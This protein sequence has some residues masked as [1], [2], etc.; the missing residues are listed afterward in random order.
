MDGVPLMGGLDQIQFLRKAQPAEV[1]TRVRQMARTV[2]GYRRF[3]LGTSDYINEN[4]PVE[5]LRAMRAAV[6]D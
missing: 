1:R 4:T 6:E 3:I 5:N 2:A